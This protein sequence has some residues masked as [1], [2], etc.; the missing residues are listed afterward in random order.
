MSSAEQQSRLLIFSSAKGIGGIE[1]NM[2]NLTRVFRQRGYETRCVINSSDVSELLLKW[3]FEQGVAAEATP[4]YQVHPRALDQVFH[5]RQMYSAWR[6]MAVSLH[7]A[8]HLS[9]KDVL[10]VWLARVPCCVVTIHCMPESLSFT[11]RMIN[12]IASRLVDAVIVHAHAVGQALIASGVP[13]RK[14]V[15][16]PLGLHL[17]EYLPTQQEARSRLGLPAEAFVVGTHARLVAEKGIDKVIE[18]MGQLPPDADGPYLLIAGQGSLHDEI[19]ALA[20]ARMG[21]RARLL[22]Q[23]GGDDFANFYA[24]LDVFALAPVGQE[25]FGMVYVEAAQFGVPSTS[26]RIG[27]VAEAVIDGETGLVVQHGDLAALTQAIARLRQDPA[28]RARLG[29]AAQARA[30]TELSETHMADEYM[31]I[32][33]LAGHPLSRGSNALA[34]VDAVEVGTGPTA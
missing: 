6:P 26:W 20:A 9:V 11:R 23:I 7:Y 18:A 29:A 14:V 16:V 12:R 2:V 3:C 32:F 31:R 27:G 30:R 13:A 22:G 21:S 8:Y 34:E 33:R 1:R 19:A 17:P 24:A 25:A 10:A 4:I 5:L 15:C 28:L